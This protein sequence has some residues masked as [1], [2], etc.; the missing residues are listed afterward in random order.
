[1]VAARVLRGFAPELGEAVRH[2]ADTARGR[3]DAIGELTDL[4]WRGLR[5]ADPPR[6]AGM[7]VT[8]DDGHPVAYAHLA[9]DASNGWTIEVLDAE[10]SLTRVTDLVARAVALVE[11]E[12]GGHLT[13]WLDRAVA[14]EHTLPS[15]G[16]RPDRELLQLRVSLPLAERPVWP[17]GITVRSFR[18]GEDDDAWLRVNNR[19]FAGHTE[20][21]N[22]T[23]AVLRER[24]REP[25]FDASGFLMA[26][27]GRELGGFC[28][29]KVHPAAP[30]AAPHALG[31]IYVIGVDPAHQGTGLGR[32][33]VTGGL[34]SLAA[35]ASRTG[36]STSTQPT[37]PR[38]GC[39]GPSDSS[40]LVAGSRT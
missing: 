20:Q 37:S 11:A 3:G 16:F 27:Q 35:A 7:L 6:D 30:P 23:T 8:A 39:T 25:W 26:W 40:S 33:L 13:M 34:D 38:C 19:A 36:C 10:G 24:E 22:W 14:L 18:P 17:D 1:M 31:E 32:A 5:G 15:L 2:L 9:R 4:T 29:T 12:G 21:G 28:W